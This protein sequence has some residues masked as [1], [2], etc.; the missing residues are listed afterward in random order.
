M[1]RLEVFR[2][3]LVDQ[4]RVLLVW[5]G[6]ALLLVAMYAAVWP[7][8]HDQPSMRD[9]L[10]QMPEAFRA[11]F[12]ST[13]AD[14]STPVGYVQVELMSF[15]GPL[16]VILYA[17]TT[18][19]SALSGEEERHT[20]D[21]ALSAPVGRARW[22]LEKFAE[23]AFGTFL[24]AAGLGVSLVAIGRFTDL[25]LPVGPTAAAMVHLGLLGL[26]F[27][28]LAMAVSAA[29]G[30]SVLS[31]AVAAALAVVAYVVNGL[32]P[33]VDWLKPMQKLSP[34]YQYVGHDPLRNGL[35][36]PSLLVACATVAILLTAAVV[37]FRRRDIPG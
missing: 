1:L 29:T 33:L 2:R 25:V 17:V 28:T 14:M 12:A 9:F 18:G 24:V 35:S 11:L 7:S 36:G 34:F 6:S 19:V 30:S 27:G 15:M 8:V 4:S 13:G 5:I 31:R 22:V 10:D 23:M 37:G 16:L 20:L 3:T 32:A 26:V 21:L